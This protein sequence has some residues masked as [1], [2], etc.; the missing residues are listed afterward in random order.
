MT[1]EWDGMDNGIGMVW[2]G[3]WNGVLLTLNWHDNDM[4]FDTVLPLG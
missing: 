3:Q 4:G 2:H 1:L